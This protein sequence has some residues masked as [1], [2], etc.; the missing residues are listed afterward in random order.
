MLGRRHCRRHGQQ[1]GPCSCSLG[2][3]SRLIEPVILYLLADGTPRYG[4][5]LLEQIPKMALTDSEI[6]VGAVYRTLQ[7]LERSGCVTSRWEPGPGGPKRHM[8]TLTPVGRA[9]LGDWAVVLER[10]GHQM[11]EFARR[12]RELLE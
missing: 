11:V 8:Y 12:C 7:M 10:R 5:E 4:Y 6:D 9:H 2:K 3:L 1:F